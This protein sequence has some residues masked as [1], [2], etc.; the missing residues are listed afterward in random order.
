MREVIVRLERLRRVR[1]DRDVLTE[2]ELWQFKRGSFRSWTACARAY[3]E[4]L[5]QRFSGPDA[6]VPNVDLDTGVITYDNR[7]D[8]LVFEATHRGIALA[9]ESHRLNPKNARHVAA[10]WILG[11]GDQLG[12]GEVKLQTQI[13][14]FWRLVLAGFAGDDIEAMSR[15]CGMHLSRNAVMDYLDKVMPA[16]RV[17][18]ERDGV[19][20]FVTSATRLYMMLR[21]E[22]DALGLI[23]GM[24]FT[25]SQMSALV[26]LVYKP[27]GCF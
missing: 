19:K 26:D 23:D 24:D 27:E 1:E 2:D 12:T 9:D 11:A 21:P 22:P 20:G 7:S 15:T 3:K 14:A 8:R 4:L 13:E 6:R 18:G 5:S 17:L 25:V 10:K 16:V